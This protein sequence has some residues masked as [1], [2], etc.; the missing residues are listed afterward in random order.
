MKPIGGAILQAG[1]PARFAAPPA[2]SSP[3]KILGN[4][5]L[6]LAAM[7]FGMIAGGGHART[8]GAGFAIEVWRPVTGFIPPLH[9]QDW[10]YLFALFQKTAQYQAHPITLAQYKALFWPM[11]IDRCWGRLMALVFCVPLV[12]FLYTRRLRGRDALWLLGIFS[13]GAAQALYGWLMV[14]QGFKPGITSPPPAW[15]APHFLSGILIYGLL[16]WTGLNYRAPVQSPVA[17][18]AGLRALLSAC[19][20]LLM[21]TMGFGALVATSNAITVYHSFP[22]MDG[23]FMP[24]GMF[25]LQP[26]WQNFLT[27]KGT[28]QFCHRML[29]SLTALTL[30]ATAIAGLRVRLPASLRD[31]FLVLA[32]LVALQYLLGMATVVLGSN[33]LGYVHELNAVLLFTAAIFA[34]HELRGAM[35]P[36]TATPGDYACPTP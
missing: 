22:S 24:P 9:A 10:S 35:A 20:V 23:H 19:L 7:V 34:R 2:P 12:W 8:I 14:L 15:A 13:L 28:V 5:C 26:F 4:W 3:D 33:D 36:S 16:L 1:L 21:A 31:S 29:A 30:L 11:F 27:N 18:A 17:N 25:T 32:G 6:L